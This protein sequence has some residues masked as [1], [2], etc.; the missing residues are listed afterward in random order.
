VAAGR[1]VKLFRSYHPDF[2][3]GGQ[4]RYFVYVRDAVDVVLWLIENETVNGLYNL[5]SG[6]AR[7][8]NDLAEAVFRAAGRT[9]QIEYIEMPKAIRGRYQYFTEA[10]LDRLRSAGYAAPS[11]TLDDG[12]GDYVRGHL[13]QSDPYR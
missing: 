6:Q 4:M 9:P 12:V 7:S 5:G 3:H 13:A 1:T 8:F 10:R 2:A 11:T